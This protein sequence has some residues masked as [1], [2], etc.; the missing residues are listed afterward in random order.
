ML[1]ALGE[2]PDRPLAA[3]PTQRAAGTCSRLGSAVTAADRARRRRRSAVP[4]STASSGRTAASTPRRRPRRSR[5]RRARSPTSCPWYSSVHRGAGYKSRQPPRPTRTRAAAALAFA[6]RDPDGDDVAIICRN[7]TE[8]INHLA[9]R[10]RLEPDDVVADDRRRAPRQPA[11]VGAAWRSAATSSAAPTARSPSTTSIAALDAVAAPA[12][13]GDHRRV[14]RHR[15]DAAARR[16]HRGRP[17]RAAC[18]CVVDAA[19]LAPHRPLPR[20]R[21]LRRVERPQD[22]RAVRRRRARRPPRLRSPTATRS[23]PAAAPSTSSISTRS[24]GPTRPSARRPGSPN[25]IGAV[26]LHA[27]DR[28]ARRASAGTRSPRTSTHGGAGCAP[29]WPP[30]DGVRL[31]GPASTATRSP[32]PRSSSTAC[33]TRSSRRGLSAEFAIGVR[34]GCFCAHP[35][36]MRL[37]DLSPDEVDRYRADVLRRRPA[38]HPRRGAGQREHLDHRR[39][40]RPAAR[41]ASARSRPASPRPS[42]TRRTRSPATSGPPATRPA[43]STPTAPSAPPRPRDG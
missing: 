4:C 26:A 32:S 11:A 33:P 5:G 15:L 29:G 36:L 24:C 7:T 34:H 42:T 19:Q 18:R 8:A 17:R 27:R 28:R 9:Y 14:E 20:R 10:L 41:R 40:R 22:V 23:S 39:R 16:D 38:R 30:I 3:P 13:A 2:R 21:R 12:A 1:R 35:Y 37:L 25:V 6:G 31:L 43:G